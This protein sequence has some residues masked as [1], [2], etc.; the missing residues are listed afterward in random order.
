[1]NKPLSYVAAL[2]LCIGCAVVGV[3]EGV[4]YGRETARAQAVRSIRAA[5]MEWRVLEFDGEC[6]HHMLTAAEYVRE[7]RTIPQLYAP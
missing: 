4:C 1:V 5:A 7:G 2:F 3:R 6:D